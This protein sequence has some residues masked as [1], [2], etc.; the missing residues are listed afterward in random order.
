MK[1]RLWAASFGSLFRQSPRMIRRLTL[2][3]LGAGT[4]SSS[5]RFPSWTHFGEISI[6]TAFLPQSAAAFR[7][8]ATPQNGSKTVIPGLVKSRISFRMS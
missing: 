3:R 1:S 4:S 5:R 8:E 7:V 6:P 2:D